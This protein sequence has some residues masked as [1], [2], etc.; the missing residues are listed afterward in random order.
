MPAAA[1]EQ[2]SFFKPLI[3]GIKIW[4]TDLENL[5]G[6]LAEQAA[7]GWAGTR[8]ALFTILDTY[9]YL[10]SFSGKQFTW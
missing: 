7:I 3:D 6:F 4:G 8:E 9:S 10:T 2:P 1:A 5:Y